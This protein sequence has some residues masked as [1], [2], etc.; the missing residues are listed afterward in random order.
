MVPVLRRALAN[1]RRLEE[2]LYE[3]GPALLRQYRK[4][5]P[6]KTGPGRPR[7]RST[8]KKGRTKS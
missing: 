2:L 7:K 8:P 4:E 1:G 3:M 5:N 6:A